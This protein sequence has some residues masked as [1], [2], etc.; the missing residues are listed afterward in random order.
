MLIGETYFKGDHV[1][2]RDEGGSEVELSFDERFNALNNR[3]D[4]I[5]GSLAVI[6]QS[7]DKLTEGKSTHGRTGTDSNA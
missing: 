5:V 4:T 1:V 2:L 6:Q 3:I 7:L